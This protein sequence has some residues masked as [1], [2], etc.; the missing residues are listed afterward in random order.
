MCTVTA[1]PDAN[2]IML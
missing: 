1:S 2:R